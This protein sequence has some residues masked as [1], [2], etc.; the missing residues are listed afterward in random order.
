MKQLFK[1]LLVSL[2]FTS[3]TSQQGE[4]SATPDQAMIQETIQPAYAPIRYSIDFNG[5]IIHEPNSFIAYQPLFEG[6]VVQTYFNLGDKINQGDPLLKVRSSE[7]AEL[8]AEQKSLHSQMKLNRYDLERMESLHKD[9]LASDKELYEVKSQLEQLESQVTKNSEVLN[10][11]GSANADGTFTIHA[12][13]SGYILE[14][15]T[16]KGAPFKEDGNPLFVLAN[17]DLVRVRI[18]IFAND[19]SKI[20]LGQEVEVT[21]PA[22]P[23]TLFIGSIDKLGQ[24]FNEE[25]QVL[26]AQAQLTNKEGLLKPGMAIS[27]RVVNQEKENYFIIP[28]ASLIF[29]N[30][31][32]F[33]VVKSKEK[34][35]IQE[36][37]IKHQDKEWAYLTSGIDLK[38]SIV[39]KHPLLIYNSLKNKKTHE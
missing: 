27:A 10:A 33:V 24:S 1:L 29:D 32:Y 38:S 17:L 28:R 36:V 31:R 15:N 19:I 16:T 6:F 39:T 20:Q 12:P 4:E 3:C 30:N 35:S 25:E 5:K 14:K 8:L 7:L 22:Y 18:N 9:D 23:D 13:L 2:F 26:Y 21:T 11:I 34:Y 37:K